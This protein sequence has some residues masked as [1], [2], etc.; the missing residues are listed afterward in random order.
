MISLPI[1][2]N[3][4]VSPDRNAAQI[5]EK[6]GERVVCTEKS[7]KSAVLPIGQHR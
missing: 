5:A 7:L 2:N 3:H 6:A 1:M 4:K